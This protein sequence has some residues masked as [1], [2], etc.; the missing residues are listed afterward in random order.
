MLVV[1]IRYDVSATRKLA[2]PRSRHSAVI[3]PIYRSNPCFTRIVR[4]M[5]I[6]MFEPFFEVIASEGATL[7]MEN[8][9]FAGPHKF[10]VMGSVARG[11]GI[12]YPTAATAI[13]IVAR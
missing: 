9:S 3:A 4:K 5:L 7:P 1:V 13:S 8:T 11:T 12:L 6:A 2:S 10:G